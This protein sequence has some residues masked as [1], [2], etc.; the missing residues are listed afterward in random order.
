MIWD[1]PSPARSSQRPI[2]CRN[3]WG[4]W[5]AHLHLPGGH[6]WRGNVAPPPKTNQLQGVI[7]LPTQTM[8][9]LRQIPPNYHTFALFDSPQMGNLMIPERTAA[10]IPK[11]WTVWRGS[12]LSGGSFRVPA[13]RFPGCKWS[14]H[15]L[16]KVHCMVMFFHSS[17]RNFNR[18][19][20]LQ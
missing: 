16:E 18:K 20:P 7:I 15:S 13:N 6:F 19:H 2:G 1:C 11:K 14:W 9:Y 4:L 17:W 3:L 12:M 8:H 5:F 10:C